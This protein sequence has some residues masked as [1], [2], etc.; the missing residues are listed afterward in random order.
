MFQYRCSD[1]NYGFLDKN[2]CFYYFFVCTVKSK[3]CFIS[4]LTLKLCGPKKKFG[5]FN[6]E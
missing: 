6:Q 5:I 4:S 2:L 1:I 3:H